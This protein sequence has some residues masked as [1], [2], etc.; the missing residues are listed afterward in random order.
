MSAPP[1]HE[2]AE[3]PRNTKVSDQPQGGS[4]SE[5]FRMAVFI[6]GTLQ[7]QGGRW[8]EGRWIIEDIQYPSGV[9]EGRT[10]A[11]LREPCQRIPDQNVFS[12]N[13]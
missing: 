12:S 4:I 11:S 9:T 2:L 3:S 5:L 13:G 7:P 10:L 1:K 6:L 8:E